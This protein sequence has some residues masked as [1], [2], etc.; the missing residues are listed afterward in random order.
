MISVVCCSKDPARAEYIADH[1]HRLLG[2]EAHE[3]ISVHNPRS[4]AEGYNFGAE[5]ATGEILI[6]SHDDIEFLDP[7]RWLR[8]LHE[9]MALFDV[10]GL[11][12][13][14]RLVSAAWAQSGPPY[15]FGQVG[16]VD[17]RV[18]P[19][20]VLIF[21]A[22]RPAVSGMQALDGLFLVVRREV[23]AT[24]QFDAQTF[25]GFHCY[26]IDFT[27]CA[28]R[29]GFK[30]A[31][32]CDLPVLHASQGNFDQTWARYAERFKHKHSATLPP[33]NPRP[34]SHAVVGARSKEEVLQILNG[35]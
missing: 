16:E 28:H 24:T 9:H 33:F 14:N 2:S 17:G 8:N 20:R 3:V 12:G 34:F 22:P 21:A 5:R 6:F 30:L 25:D 13:T 18:A 32:A 4:L 1:Y 23:L 15:T 31:V 27:Y 19:F 35:G 10:L 11:A 29:A 7:A 26:D